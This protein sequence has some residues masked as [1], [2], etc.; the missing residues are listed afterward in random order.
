MRALLA[1]AILPALFWDGGPETASQLR[2]AHIDSIRVP[3]ANVE[4]WMSVAGITPLPGDPAHAVKLVTPGV[5]YF[6]AEASPTLAP[7]IKSNGW[8][9][10]RSPG[11]QF[12]VKAPGA[13]APLAAAEAY[14]FDAATMI[15]SD[16]DGLAPL[17][18]MLTFLKTLPEERLPV[19]ANVGFLDDGTPASAERMNLMIVRNLLFRR[20]QAPD[21]AL[22]L[23]V[24]PGS[25]DYPDAAWHNPDL[26]EHI[27]RA[28]VTDEK[29]LVRI[30]GTEV[31][32]ARLEGDGTEL[33]VHLLNYASVQR[34]V[35]GVRVRVLGRYE[36]H[37]VYT[38]GQS[39]AQLVDYTVEPDATEFTI[40]ELKTYAVID[41]SR[42]AVH[43]YRR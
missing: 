1:F 18:D 14:V 8:R 23:L 37:K 22:D 2:D 20:L 31:V 28:K 15:Q 27:M 40:P 29:R 16:A 17:G 5:E 42:F 13:A 41:L 38:P 24:R 6:T 10:L 26:L 43:Q 34:Q 39:D 7:Y 25:A 30:Y 11:A 21:L 3:E 4:P 33:D 35:E 32:V 9:Y 36:G 12:V 19:L